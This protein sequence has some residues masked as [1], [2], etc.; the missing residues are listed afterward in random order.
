MTKRDPAEGADWA[1]YYESHT[2]R[3]VRDLLLRALDRLGGPPRDAVAVDLGCGDG[4][5]TAALLRAGFTVFA[6]D[7]S[8]DAIRRTLLAAGPDAVRLT[9][10]VE[11]FATYAVPPADLVYAGFSLPFCRPADFPKVWSRVRAALRPGGVVGVTLF[12]ERDSWASEWDMTFVSAQR[13][14]EL[15]AGLDADIL[16]EER[17]GEAYSG[18]KHWHVFDVVARRLVVPE[19]T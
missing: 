2:G 17:D 19:N 5:E 14:D 15:T 10:T 12:G 11:G 3:P 4:T 18:P 7:S 6:V 13:V 8:G 1:G 9:A 16:E